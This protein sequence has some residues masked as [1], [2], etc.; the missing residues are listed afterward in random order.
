MC[1]FVINNLITIMKKYM[2]LLLFFILS[3]H[4]QAQEKRIE[5]T[6]SKIPDITFKKIKEVN[7]YETYV[8]HVKQPIDHS[9]SSKG[10]FRQKVY[11]SHRSFEKPTVLVTAGYDVNKNRKSELTELLESNQILVEHRYFGESIPDSLDYK[12]LNLKQATA[13]LHKIRGLFSSLYSNKWISTGVSKGGATTIFYRYFYPNDIDVSVPYVAP[14]NKSY[15]EQRIYNFLDTIGT[16]KCRKKIKDFQIK[17]LE[18]REK[19]VPLLKFYSLGARVD[20][21]YLSLS[22]AFEYAVLEYPFSFWQWGHDCN[23]IP[24]KTASIEEIAKHFIA[25]SNISFF[26][27]NT[28]RQLSSHYY[29]SATEMGYYGYETSEF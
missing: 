3:L 16:D 11:L 8:L 25:V 13:D 26:S 21:S 29:Q 19:I 6:L 24:T 20:Y 7:G 15:E 5:S 22:E 28:I 27:D 14:I 1:S 2:F 9:D 10:F 18:N 17:V 4:I 12:F 23:K